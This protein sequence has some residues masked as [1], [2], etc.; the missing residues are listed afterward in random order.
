MDVDGRP[1]ASIQQQKELV[2]AQPVLRYFD[3]N[4]EV[5]I[6]SNASDYGL[7]ATLLLH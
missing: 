4:I 2:V 7:G 6:Q 1:E 5:T 3:P